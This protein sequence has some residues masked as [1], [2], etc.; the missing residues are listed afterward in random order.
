MKLVLVNIKQIR[1]FKKCTK[2]IVVQD[3]HQQLKEFGIKEKDLLQISL[4]RKNLSNR[5]KLI[6]EKSLLMN[7]NLNILM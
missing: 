3:F 6:L 7:L 2:K 4:L 5:P 1:T